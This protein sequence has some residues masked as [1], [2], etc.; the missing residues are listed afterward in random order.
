MHVLGER[1]YKVHAFKKSI[2]EERID[3][4]M[5]EIWSKLIERFSS[6]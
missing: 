3:E 2:F 6:S 5:F 1:S 4:G